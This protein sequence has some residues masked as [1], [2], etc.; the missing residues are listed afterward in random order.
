M[1]EIRVQTGTSKGEPVFTTTKYKKKSSNRIRRRKTRR[2]KRTRKDLE[3]LGKKK[4]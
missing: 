4:K 2:K 1:P 3:I